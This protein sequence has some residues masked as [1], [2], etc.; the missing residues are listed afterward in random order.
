MSK[1][2]QYISAKNKKA[3]TLGKRFFVF[4]DK[5]MLFVDGFSVFFG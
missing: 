5:N 4:I 2:T 1:I 3:L